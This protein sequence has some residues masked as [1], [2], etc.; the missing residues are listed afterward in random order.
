MLNNTLKQQ[1]LPLADKNTFKPGEVYIIRVN[2]S[3]RHTELPSWLDKTL[4][5]WSR[6]VVQSEK[7]SV[8]YGVDDAPVSR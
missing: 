4:V 6:D 1:E 7:I 8:E 2:L 3:M 5:F